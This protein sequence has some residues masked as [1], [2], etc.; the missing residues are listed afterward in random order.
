ML[1]KIILLPLFF[2]SHAAADVSRAEDKGSDA[3][4]GK[5]KGAVFNLDDYANA[6]LAPELM[7]HKVFGDKR[8]PAIV[9]VPGLGGSASSYSRTGELLGKS[10]YVLTLSQ[11]GHGGTASAG[12]IMSADLLA[13]DVKAK[14]ASLGI[15]KAYIY[16]HSMGARTAVA[17]GGLFPD[18]TLG[19][20]IDDMHMKNV[21]TGRSYA[22]RHGLNDVAKRLP[23]SFISLE[24]AQR[25]IAAAALDVKDVG[26]R[27]KSALSEAL[28][29]PDGRF[30]FSSWG[31]YPYQ[32]LAE[33]LSVHLNQITAT[34]TPLLVLNGQAVLNG[35]GLAHLQQHAPDAYFFDYHG[36]G[37]DSYT[38]RRE[39]RLF[40]ET[41]RVKAAMA[42]GGLDVFD[43]TPLPLKLTEYKVYGAD[44]QHNG[45]VL[46]IHGLGGSIESW[47]KNAPELIANLS[48]D[49]RV[50]AYSI[51]GHGNTATVGNNYSLKTMADDAAYLISNL[52]LGD[53][54]V[55]GHSLGARI[56]LQ[57]AT[58]HPDLV[59]SLITEDMHFKGVRNA[60]SLAEMF[61]DV[62]ILKT[63]PASFSDRDALLMHVHES[64]LSG[65]MKR[66]LFHGENALVTGADGRVRVNGW[67][68]FVAA[69]GEEM[70]DSLKRLTKPTL[71]FA[72]DQDRKHGNGEPVAFLRQK[73]IDHIREFLSEAKI[74]VFEGSGHGIHVEKLPDYIVAVREHLRG[75]AKPSNPGQGC[76]SLFGD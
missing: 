49:Y 66:E 26:P 73:G 44:N 37:V 45:T 69:I 18:S 64:G 33:D 55:I 70:G 7:E 63:F 29:N 42:S 31:L 20:I 4:A 43:Q 68:I 75:N 22:D 59:R 74:V 52:D 32:G 53:V 1:K 12:N 16:G 21:T 40:S 19:V 14:M 67:H 11:R 76:W 58:D 72:A 54:H 23:P 56:G 48:K 30:R 38:L 41:T 25:L 34:K 9:L 10:H 6:P 5:G 13:R 57:L 36:H 27:V 62:D 50:V 46:L 61:A 47:T 15:E 71:F 8:N 17:F 35:V 2:A 3:T 51:R 28:H 60:K 39:L 24:E 65:A